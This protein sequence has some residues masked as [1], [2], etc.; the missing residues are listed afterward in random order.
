MPSPA[1]QE[2]LE[3][4]DKRREQLKGQYKALKA[5]DNPVYRDLMEQ[6][7]GLHAG[8]MTSATTEMD[9]INK[10][11]LYLQEAI[12]YEKLRTYISG[13]SE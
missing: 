12:A 11:A 3:R 8:A 7:D 1:R 13:M 2:A 6:L 10:K 4:A 5:S 9:N